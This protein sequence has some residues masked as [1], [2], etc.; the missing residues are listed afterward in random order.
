VIAL[1]SSYHFTRRP[2]FFAQALTML[3]D[4]GALTTSD[5][6]LPPRIGGWKLALLRVL[7]RGFHMPACNLITQIEYIAQLEAAGFEQ[8]VCISI[9]RV[10]VCV[11]VFVCLLCVCVACDCV[12]S[13]SQ[14]FRD[15]SQPTD[16]HSPIPCVSVPLLSTLLPP[17]SVR[18]TSQPACIDR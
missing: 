14:P 9:D 15:R 12:A 6:V 18:K 10:C 2:D 5:I 17:S 4:S 11:C 8:V 13:V 7:V 16:S 1:D 3:E